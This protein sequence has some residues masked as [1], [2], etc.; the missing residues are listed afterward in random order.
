M[1][2]RAQPSVKLICQRALVHD[3]HSRWR[4]EV[5]LNLRHRYVF[6][7]IAKTKFGFDA[8]GL[9]NQDTRKV[10]VCI[11]LKNHT[12]QPTFLPVSPRSASQHRV[13]RAKGLLSGTR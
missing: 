2:T 5:K 6:L 9:P 11:N 8:A 10:S 12:G 4:L 13:A 7:P 1:S 3:G